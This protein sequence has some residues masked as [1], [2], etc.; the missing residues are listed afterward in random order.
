MN[1]DWQAF[2]QGYGAQLD[3]TGISVF[4]E[5]APSPKAALLVDASPMAV[6]EIT[7]DDATGFL[8]SQFCNDIEIVSADQG[9]L[10]GYC[11]PKGRL[12]AFFSVIAVAGGYRLLLP[13]TVVEVFVKRLQIYVLRAKV[14]V[15]LR[16]D[17]VC[18]GLVAGADGQLDVTDRALPASKLAVV[19]KGELQIVR[20][21]DDYTTGAG[22]QRYLCVATPAAMAVLWEQLAS[23][24]VCA[25]FDRWRFADIGAGVPR[26]IEQ[27][28]EAFVPQMVNLHLIDALSFTKGC[29]P[30]QEIVAR[31]QYLGKLK[32]HMRRYR[33]DGENVPVPG[34]AVHAGEDSAA[35][36]VVDA[37]RGPNGVELLAVV[38]TGAAAGLSVADQPMQAEDLPY[39]LPT[40]VTMD[41]EV[42]SADL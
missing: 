28:R 40:L 25:A 41:T 37:V 34:A 12:L 2:L 16:D 35:G 4:A 33:V 38:K 13:Q 19:S 29:Y 9:Q 30:G 1:T 32:R 7:G 42:E 27:T 21:H 36:Q 11:T 17:L 24:A 8:Q 18:V 26:L 6:V 23:T 22:R 39:P 3:A 31:M 14:S 20:W 10:S 5:S 15:A